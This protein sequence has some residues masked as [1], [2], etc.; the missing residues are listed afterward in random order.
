MRALIVDD[1]ELARRGLRARLERAGVSI[2]GECVNGAEALAGSK[3][4]LRRTNGS[5][6]PA[7]VPNITTPIRL[8]NTV[9]A[10]RI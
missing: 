9:S 10:T 1:E 7:M 4:S 3:P 8:M 2:V 6:E 5:T